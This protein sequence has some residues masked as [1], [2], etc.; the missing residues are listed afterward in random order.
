MPK[1]CRFPILSHDEPRQ[2]LP[3]FILGSS[4]VFINFARNGELPLTLVGKV[5]YRILEEEESRKEPRAEK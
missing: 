1:K 3:G 2:H 4:C 5:A